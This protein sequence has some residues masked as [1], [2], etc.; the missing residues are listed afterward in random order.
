MVNDGP[1][2][3]TLIGLKNCPLDCAYCI[4]KNV[5]KSEYFKNVSPAELLEEVLIDYCYFVTTGGGVTFGGAEPL[6]SIDAISE[7]LSLKPDGMAVNIET[8][9]NVKINDKV[10][11]EFATKIDN[12]IIDIKSL[13]SDIYL[14]YTKK[15]P[16]VFLHNLELLCKNGMQD[17][18]KIR[19][20]IIPKYTE[21]ADA[22]RYSERIK[23]MGFNNIE[24]FGYIVKTG[25]NKERKAISKA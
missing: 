3:T 1:G 11:T 2:V 18:C 19:I 14:K 21:E 15:S 5:T 7:F 10:F 17:K 13:D 8:S 25:K 4:N 6:L 12:F 22:I 24:I 23:D 20:P 9:L 16:D